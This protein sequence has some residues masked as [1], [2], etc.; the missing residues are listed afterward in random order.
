M[1]CSGNVQLLFGFEARVR[2]LHEEMHD[3]YRR[4][5]LV[6]AMRLGTAV[7]DEWAG[8]A[9]DVIIGCTHATVGIAATRL[10]DLNA[11]VQHLASAT[12]PVHLERSTFEP[13]HLCALLALVDSK[14]GR[15]GRVDNLLDEVVRRG[16]PA[17]VALAYRARAV[18]VWRS[19]GDA[20]A[21]GQLLEQS[22]LADPPAE[23][24]LW[25]HDGIYRAS[26]LFDAG[27]HHE[28][29]M[30][31][32]PAI[33]QQ[34]RCLTAV[35]EED[36]AGYADLGVS[37]T[38]VGRASLADGDADTAELLFAESAPYLDGRWY[39]LA[40]LLLGRAELAL[41][42]SDTAD[43]HV[44]LDAAAEIAQ[45]LGL[46]PTMIELARVRAAVVVAEG[47][48]GDAAAILDAAEALARSLGHAAD[49]GHIAA[50]RQELLV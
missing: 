18:L 15:Y 41:S 40:Y 43:A 31:G 9:D 20:A 47:S 2:R 29:L 17:K 28:A 7:L 33:E 37:L 35:P 30:F 11:A 27:R 3:A 44:Q 13:A 45:A 14:Q 32:L 39:G 38:I 10:E 48:P 21:A 36:R 46:Q 5:D 23:P 26:F 16:D 19:T 22:V 8:D 1:Q 50:L 25:W 24:G 12:S 4:D 6:E 49:L 34:R 42:R